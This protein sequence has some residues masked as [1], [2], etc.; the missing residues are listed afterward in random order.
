M[1]FHWLLIAIMLSFF[2]YTIVFLA[3]G[4]IFRFFSE[5][6]REPDEQLGYLIFSLTMGQLL[7]LAMILFGVAIYFK[8]K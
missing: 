1:I 2:T 3:S 7:S 6:F 8:I 5:S 4:L